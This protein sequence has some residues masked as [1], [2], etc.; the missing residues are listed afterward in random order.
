ML[1]HDISSLLGYVSLGPEQQF[2]PYFF[3]LLAW[4]GAM[5]VAILQWPVVA[6][7]KR[8]RAARA[9]RTDGAPEHADELEAVQSSH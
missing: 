1:G 9:D 4:G 8:L 2:I 6:M 7:L 5:A 3:A